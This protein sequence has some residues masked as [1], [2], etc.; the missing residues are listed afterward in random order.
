MNS[1]DRLFLGFWMCITIALV[2]LM[3]SLTMYN[4]RRDALVRLGIEQG[5]DPLVVG[6]SYGTVNPQVCQMLSRS[7]D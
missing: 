1:T 3:V 7:K 5:K 2:T 6:C 4:S